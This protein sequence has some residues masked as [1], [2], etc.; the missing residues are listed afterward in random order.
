MLYIGRPDPHARSSYASVCNGKVP[1]F[2]SLSQ[3]HRTWRRYFAAKLLKI[4][5]ASGEIRVIHSHMLPR[6]PV[7]WS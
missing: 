3:L 1:T 6:H 4:S 7:L 5:V 2:F